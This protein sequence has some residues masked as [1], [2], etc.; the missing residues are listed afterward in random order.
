MI[1][2]CFIYLVYFLHDKNISEM[3]SGQGHVMRRDQGQMWAKCKNSEQKSGI[4]GV[5]KYI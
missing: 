1:L 5:S 2:S 3:I 4:L